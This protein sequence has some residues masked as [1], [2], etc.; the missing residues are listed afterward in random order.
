[1]RDK[2]RKLTH[3]DYAALARLRYLMRSFAA[4]SA[5]AAQAQGLPARQHQA[6]LAIKGHAPDAM[7]AGVLAEHL[8]ITPHAATELIDR[9][10]D[11][12]L[13]VRRRDPLDR[14]R[15]ILALTA[16]AE[17]T[18]RALSLA[19]LREIRATTPALLAVLGKLERG[20]HD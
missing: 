20:G 19:H 9:L 11:A 12:G 10:A 14:R 6:L 13:A 7:T 5:A 2:S 1:M 16:K 15:F 3:A 4:F 17:R 8:L 18:L